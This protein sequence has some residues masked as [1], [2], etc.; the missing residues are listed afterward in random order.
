MLVSTV[1]KLLNADFY[2]TFKEEFVKRM[3]VHPQSA[4]NVVISWQIWDL[5]LNLQGKV[6][7]RLGIIFQLFTKLESLTIH[8]AVQDQ[9]IFLATRMSLYIIFFGLG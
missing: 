4:L 7:S 1:E 9:G 2:L 5:T 6:T 3:K 8:A